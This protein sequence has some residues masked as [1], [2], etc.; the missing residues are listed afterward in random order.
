MKGEVKYM[1][2]DVVSVDELKRKINTM[3]VKVLFIAIEDFN[4]IIVTFDR[5]LTEEEER[6]L[7]LGH[8]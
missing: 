7:Y 6:F 2:H 1:F 8:S 5:H 4:T 3:N